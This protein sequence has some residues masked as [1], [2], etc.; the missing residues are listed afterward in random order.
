LEPPKNFRKIRPREQNKTPTV[1][2]FGE[3]GS[4]AYVPALAI[5]PHLTAHLAMG[6]SMDGT[7][8]AHL[9]RLLFL[10]RAQPPSASA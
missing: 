7:G 4:N 9:S 5:E 1:S 10:G 8:P 3:C 2:F 6:T